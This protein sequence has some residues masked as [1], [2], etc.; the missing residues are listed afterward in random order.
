MGGA[1]GDF[2]K[3]RMSFDQRPFFVRWTIRTDTFQLQLKD[4]VCWEPARHHLP[5]NALLIPPASRSQCSNNQWFKG[6]KGYRDVIPMKLCC[7]WMFFST[8]FTAG[9]KCSSH[10]CA[11]GRVRWEE[12]NGGWFLPHHYIGFYT[13]SPLQGS[14]GLP[15]DIHKLL[16]M[17][18][19]SIFF[20][21][22]LK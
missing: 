16:I 20:S 8:P 10:G 3:G 7:G 6:T 12:R 15:L 1:T 22:W 21:L 19:K 5:H 2:R 4:S 11:Q 18:P 17:C 9:M 14:S 13:K